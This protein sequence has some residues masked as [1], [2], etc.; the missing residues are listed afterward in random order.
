MARLRDRSDAAGRL[1]R[2]LGHY[3]GVNPLVLAVPRG[4]VP[5]G[6]VIA[7]AL[8]GELD[9]ALVSKLGAPTDPETAIGSVDERGAVVLNPR[10]GWIGYSDAW[11]ADETERRLAALRRRADAWRRERPAADPAGRSV[12]LV[13]DGAATGSTLS[14]A[15]RL[16]RQH[17][18]AR[19]V[20]AVA[21]APRGVR[22]RLRRLADEL[23]CLESPWLFLSVSQ[24]FRRFEPVDD[25]RVRELLHASAAT[26]R[27]ER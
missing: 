14:G 1:A 9:V 15:I 12:I 19:L 3:A 6:R 25:E 16:L 23:V 18:P 8:G 27:N 17:E 21:V 13:D 5:L 2:R 26:H 24:V 10:A 20:V 22:R 11:L 7:D 4:G